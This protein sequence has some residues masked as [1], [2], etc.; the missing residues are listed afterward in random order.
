MRPITHETTK[1]K[2]TSITKKRKNEAEEENARC[3]TSKL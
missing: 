1:I 3:E 2:Q